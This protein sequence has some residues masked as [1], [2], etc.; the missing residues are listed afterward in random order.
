MHVNKFTN[1]VLVILLFFDSPVVCSL[2]YLSGVPTE[3]EAVEEVVLLG[4]G[5]PPVR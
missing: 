2:A 4:V 3:T 5:L 1:W